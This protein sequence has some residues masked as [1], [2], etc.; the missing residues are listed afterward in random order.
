MPMQTYTVVRPKRGISVKHHGMLIIVLDALQLTL[1]Q[2]ADKLVVA[3]G[4]HFC[5]QLP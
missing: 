4:H 5:V 1:L 3:Q 2:V